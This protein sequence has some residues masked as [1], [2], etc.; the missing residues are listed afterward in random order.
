VR[1]LL[2]QGQAPVDELEAQVTAAQAENQRLRLDVAHLESPTRIV[3]EAQARLG[4]VPP[5][6]VVYLPPLTQSPPTQSLPVQ[7][8]PVQSPPTLPAG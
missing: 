6:A 1:V 8:L 5:A 4:M 7:S 2:A 3:A